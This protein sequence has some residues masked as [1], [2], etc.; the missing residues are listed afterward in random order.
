MTLE[1]THHSNSSAWKIIASI[2]IVAPLAIVTCGLS[3]MAVIMGGGAL[4]GSGN[5]AVGILLLGL[6]GLAGWYLYSLVASLWLNR[7]GARIILGLIVG[8]IILSIMVFN[9]TD[10]ALDRSRSN[11]PWTAK[12]Y[13]ETYGLGTV[14]L[15]GWGLTLFLIFRAVYAKPTTISNHNIRR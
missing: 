13:G 12:N 6:A 11:S 7:R 10:D 15:A 4:I 8:L 9:I 5:A 14:G 3:L 2:L 1:S